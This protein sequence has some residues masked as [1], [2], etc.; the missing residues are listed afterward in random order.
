[1][2]ESTTSSIFVRSG[3]PGFF[4]LDDSLIAID[5]ESGY[6][7]ALNATSARIWELIAV[8]TCVSAIRDS[9][10]RE[11]DVDPERCL[12]DIQEILSALKDAELAMECRG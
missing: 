6:C 8:P 9:L 12:S 4:R 3:N 2:Q 5:K 10:C 7:Y 11:F 1:M